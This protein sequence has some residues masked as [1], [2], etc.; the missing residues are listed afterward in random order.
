MPPKINKDVEFY[1]ER[2]RMRKLLK[3]IDNI[4]PYN[5]IPISQTNYGSSGTSGSSG[6]SGTSG[7]TKP[8]TSTEIKGKKVNFDIQPIESKREKLKIKWKFWKKQ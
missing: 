5:M 3:I 1:E 8:N 7:D 4:T 2:E 6:S